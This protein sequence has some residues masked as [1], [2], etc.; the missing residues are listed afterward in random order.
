MLVNTIACSI[1]VLQM[2]ITELK[3]R[4]EPV[5]RVLKDQYKN[6]FQRLLQS[7][8]TDLNAALADKKKVLTEHTEGLQQRIEELK[9]W[10]L[11]AG[12]VQ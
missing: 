7:V 1:I 12:S 4:L 2:I 9:K 8:E 10:K 3:C 11:Q 6:N 5:R